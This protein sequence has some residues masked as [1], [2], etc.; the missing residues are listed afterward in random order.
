M[1]SCIMPTRNRAAFL[2]SAIDCFLKQDYPNK[3]LIILGDNDEIH[4]IELC[5]SWPVRYVIDERKPIGPK[6]NACCELAQGEIICHYDD[7][8]WSA[9]DRIAFQ[10]EELQKTGK[11]VTG[12]ATLYFWDTVA[13]V[14]RRYRSSVN[15]YVCGTTLCYLK[16]FW[17][18]HKFK[19]VDH[20][21]DNDFVYPALNQIA[22]SKDAS[23][24]VAR[25]HDSHTSSK[26]GII[27]TVSNEL[28]PV[29]FWANEELRLA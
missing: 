22:G 6:R 11:P 23:H 28:L 1:V 13:K 7:D 20:G 8:D 17:E 3:E 4:S 16:S 18:T 27:G 5:S 12:F 29:G 25:I 9:P 24:M 2:K 15:G 19:D 21:E 10:V 14:S 26:V